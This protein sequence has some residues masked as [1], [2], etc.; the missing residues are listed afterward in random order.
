MTNILVSENKFKIYNTSMNPSLQFQILGNIWN[1]LNTTNSSS[2][3][4][5]LEEM[6][7]P[8]LSVLVQSTSAAKIYYFIGLVNST[9]TI[10]IP[11]PLY[12]IH[13][14]LLLDTFTSLQLRR[15]Y[16]FPLFFLPLGFQSLNIFCA[17]SILYF[18]SIQFTLGILHSPSLLLCLIF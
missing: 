15:L 16:L 5:I 4:N 14:Y 12:Q 7:I 17:L 11:L 1:H 10:L 2:F 3:Q 18:Y 9:A 13:T 6:D 8:I